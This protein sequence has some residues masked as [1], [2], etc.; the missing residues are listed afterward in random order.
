MMGMTIL[1]KIVVWIEKEERDIKIFKFE[2]N[3]VEPQIYIEKCNLI[4]REGI[5]LV[6]RTKTQ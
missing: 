5:K 2:Q 3:Q 6:S 1:V 4:D